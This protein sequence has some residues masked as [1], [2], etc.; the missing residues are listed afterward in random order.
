MAKMSL[1]KK[2]GGVNRVKAKGGTR[3]LAQKAGAKKAA[4]TRAENKRRNK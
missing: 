3:T 1:F 2:G 4:K